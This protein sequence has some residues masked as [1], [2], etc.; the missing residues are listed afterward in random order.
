MKNGHNHLVRSIPV[1]IWEAAR[2]RAHAE[3]RAMRN[4][5]I[6]AP[7]LYAAGRLTPLSAR[8]RPAITPQGRMRGSTTV[9]MVE[10]RNET[11]DCHRRC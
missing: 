2:K 4:V 1:E 6:V 5:V 11:R 8:Q 7:E 9:V 3:E 10:N